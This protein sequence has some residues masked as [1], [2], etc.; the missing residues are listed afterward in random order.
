MVH[1]P[2]VRNLKPAIFWP[3]AYALLL[4]ASAQ[5]PAL[6]IA[7]CFLSPVLLSLCGIHGGLVP[8]AACAMLGPAAVWLL[9]GNTLAPL[10][11]SLYLLPYAALHVVC[12][13]RKISFF[14]AVGAHVALLAVCQTA[15][16]LILRPYLGGDLF[17]GG[18]DF[19][20]EQ[21][22]SSPGGDYVLLWMYQYNILSVPEEMIAGAGT[23]TPA[24]RAELINSL[25]TL[26]KDSLYVLLPTM[27]INN[28]ILTGVFGMA[29]PVVSARRQKIP[30]MEMPPFAAWHLSRSAGFKVLLLGLGNLLLVPMFQGPGASLAGNISNP[31][32]G[33]AG[34]MMGAAFS[35][36]FIIQ[37]AALMEFFQTR[38]GTKSPIRWLWPCVI[39]LLFRPLLMILGIA[40]QFLNI[41]GLRKPKDREEG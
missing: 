16:L 30:V 8:M 23:L 41:R 24:I 22:S 9:F 37:G 39:Y 1:Y 34:T 12:F 7:V 32:I 2:L 5:I 31:G 27:I 19:L 11:C 17:A 38:A 6:F 21:I 33:L 13:S 3:V 14:Q 28:A 20:V 26:L 15:I 10:L 25:R 4:F 18:A 29:F 40:D 35:T 36:I